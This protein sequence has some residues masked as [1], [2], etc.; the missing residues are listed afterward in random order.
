MTDRSSGIG[1]SP[2]DREHAHK[3]GELKKRA[4]SEAKKFFA[5]FVY[6]WVLFGLFQ[7][8]NSLLDKE[9]HVTLA[10]HGLAIVN[11]LIFAKVMLLAEGLH[12]GRRFERGPLIYPITIKSL[13]FAVVFL[14]FHVA[15]K[16][17]VGAITGKTMAESLPVLSGV[18]LIGLLTLAAI[19]TIALVPFFTFKE[20]ARI[21]GPGVLYDMVLKA[22]QAGDSPRISPDVARQA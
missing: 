4:V 18:G 20:V 8:Y 7:L 2:A 1:N 16:S 3:S 10:T 11:A 19:V 6:L 17:I 5:I 21:L 14:A 12:L 13:L 22:R 9:N 15:E